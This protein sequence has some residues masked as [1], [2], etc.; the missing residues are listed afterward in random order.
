MEFLFKKKYSCDITFNQKTLHLE[1]E[2]EYPIGSFGNT[3]AAYMAWI[4]KTGNQFTYPPI[5]NIKEEK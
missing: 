3:N 4:E 5:S 1:Y 2:S